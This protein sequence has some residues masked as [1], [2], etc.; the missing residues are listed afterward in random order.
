LVMHTF[1]GGIVFCFAFC[2]VLFFE[3]RDWV[4]VLAL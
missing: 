3:T 2:F 4:Q 1:G